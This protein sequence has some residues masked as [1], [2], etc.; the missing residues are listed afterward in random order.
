MGR[1]VCLQLPAGIV[2]NGF[3]AF[4]LVFV[5]MT[6]LF[7]VAPIFGRRN[8]PAYFKIGFSFFISLI[9]INTMIL[10]QAAYGDSLPGYVLLVMKEFLVGLS[11]GYVAYL[12]YTAIYIAGELIDMKIGF[13]VVNVVDPMSNIQVPITSNMYF[14]A[15]MLIFLSMGGHHMLIKALYDSFSTLP[16]GRLAY[17]AGAHNIVMDLFGTVLATGFKMAA[18]V[19][20]TSIIADIALG[21]IS[22]MV[23]Q[24]NIF[25]IG[26]PHKILVG[27]IIVAITIPMFIEIMRSVFEL[28]GMTVDNYLK[29]LNPG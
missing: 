23:P 11:M 22:K 12:S 1:E 26:M 20:A 5:R 29:E 17:G 27:L 4:L 19:V 6:G 13:G 15:S 24:M 9:L 3:E 2:I 10:Q 14:I 28:M 8:V 7:V 21:T 18:P 16:P 25:V